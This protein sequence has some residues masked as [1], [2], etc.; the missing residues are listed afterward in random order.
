MK[1]L[2]KLCGLISIILFSCGKKEN[3]LLDINKDIYFP[4]ASSGFSIKTD[5]NSGDILISSYNPWQGADNES[6]HLLI[7]K[8]GVK[9]EDYEG[10]YINGE[11]KRIICM[12][13]THIA[14]LDAL[15]ATD[16][17]VGVS[18]AEY[19]S[20]PYIRG[21]ANKIPDIGYEGF[22][23][24][25][26]LVTVNP[27][28][29]LLFSVNGASNME[30]KLKELGIPY[31]YVGDYVEED[32][33][34]KAEWIVPVAEVIGKRE[35]GIEK[36]NEIRNNYLALKDKVSDTNLTRPSVMVNAPFLDSWFMPSIKSYVARMIEDSGATFIYKKNTGN[37]S[38]PIDMEEAL[39]LVSD[40]DY[41]IN[42]SDIQSVYE[43]KSI[44]PEFASTPCV[45]EGKIYNNNKIT[46]PGGGND[47]YESGVVHPD[48]ILRDLIKIFHPEL[49]EEDFTYY[50]R[51][52]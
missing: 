5:E 46:S 48:L 35:V 47:C 37:S 10:Q 17:I 19:I 43:L 38:L 21:N 33:I 6:S 40:A 18:G 44:L 15:D 23:D 26:T 45:A 8:N 9:P 50:H 7:V 13:S 4:V 24:Y 20:N 49:I 36:F 3:S 1:N 51:L 39:K 30:P 42:I 12:S 14:M 22:I 31:M 34:G 27:D 2:Y 11:A 28:L 52:Q 16:R 25:E 41:W 29:M 32:P